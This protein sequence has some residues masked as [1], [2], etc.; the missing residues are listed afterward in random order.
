[1]K[2]KGLNS[3]LDKK[4]TTKKQAAANGVE[5]VIQT[6]TVKEGIKE[7]VEKEVKQIASDE[8]VDDD[9]Y[10]ALNYMG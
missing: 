4:K 8:E 5:T 10:E 7:T 6:E 9:T 3:F 2:N 1:M